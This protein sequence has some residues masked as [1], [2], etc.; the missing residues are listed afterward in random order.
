MYQL[1]SGLRIIE[2]SS[3]VASP[4][5][6]LYLAQ[7]GAEVIRVDN[8]GGGPDFNRWPKTNEGNSLYWEGLNR[9]KKSVAVNMRTDEGKALIQRLATAPG[10]NAGVLLTNFPLGGFLSYENLKAK[11]DDVIVARVMGQ[12][13]GGPALDYTVNCALGLPYMT[14]PQELGDEPVNHVLPAWDLLAGAYAAFALM[15]AERKRNM[16]G[17]G[18]EVRIPLADLGITSIANM[19]QIAEVLY[20][21]ESRKRHGNEI[22]GAFG[23]DFLTAD[24]KRLMIM[25]LTSRQWRGLVS[26]LNIEIEIASIE[27]QRGISFDQDE[28]VRYEHADILYPLVESCVSKRKYDELTEALDAVGGCWGAYQTMREAAD[29]PD[30][31]KN[32]PIF[33][34]MKNTS[35]LTYPTPGSALTFP[36]ETRGVPKKSP[37]LGQDTEEVLE[38]LLNMNKS[39]IQTLQDGGHIGRAES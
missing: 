1:L 10:A 11:R 12:A 35:G 28:G 24:N 6:G 8:I 30:L 2:A 39:E 4:S 37:Q 16:T 22:Y 23:R 26:V 17:A 25:A 15:A 29:D 20:N 32:N 9:A 7:L 38:E 34:D 33:T 5:A 13:N 36:E 31:V 3:F 27:K 21:D 19:G 18:G 14:G